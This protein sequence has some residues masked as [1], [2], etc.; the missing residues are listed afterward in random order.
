MD[1]FQLLIYH[2][3]RHQCLGTFQGKGNGTAKWIT[4]DGIKICAFYHSGVPE[5]PRDVSVRERSKGSAM[6]VEWKEA[7]LNSSAPVL[8][9]IQ[10]KYSIGYHYSAQHSTPWKQKAQVGSRA[11]FRT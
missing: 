5:I 4:I 6:E 7:Y 1:N 2:I 11:L 10:S 9:I 8:Y 3:L